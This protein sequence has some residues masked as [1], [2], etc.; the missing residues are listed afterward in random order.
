MKSVTETNL[1]VRDRSNDPFV[2][3][4]E[5]RAKVVGEGGN[6]G[7]T[8]LGRIEFELAGGRVNTD[9]IDNSAGVN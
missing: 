5:L 8:Q 2:S 9:F 1:D 4:Y 3:S 7:L 6:L